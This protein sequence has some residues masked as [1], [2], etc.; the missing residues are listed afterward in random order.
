MPWR[1]RLCASVSGWSLVGEPHR[2]ALNV[3]AACALTN[4]YEYTLT[5]RE[6]SRRRY[7]RSIALSL[8][9]CEKSAGT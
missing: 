1:N 6:I 7:C 3:S 5:L 2:W 4:V 9:L 8:Q